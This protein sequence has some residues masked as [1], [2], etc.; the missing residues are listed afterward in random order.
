MELSLHGEQIKQWQ[1]RH[2]GSLLSN[3]QSDGFSRSWSERLP[4]ARLGSDGVLCDTRRAEPLE[5]YSTTHDDEGHWATLYRGENDTLFIDTGTA[6]LRT[7]EDSR[8]KG[9]VVAFVLSMAMTI[10]GA[11][12]SIVPPLS[13]LGAPML[14]GGVLCSFSIIGIGKLVDFE[15]TTV[16]A[17]INDRDVEV[18]PDKSDYGHARLRKLLKC[19]L[20]DRA[21]SLIESS[22]EYELLGR[23][24]EHTY[25]I[26][27]RDR[28]G[29]F[30]YSEPYR[31]MPC[32][33][34]FQGGRDYVVEHIQDEYGPEVYCELFEDELKPA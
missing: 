32:N 6:E 8:L 28:D 23:P 33:Q 16:P 13:S 2:G 14:L 25:Y 3:R 20:Y 19:R 30:L 10:V 15:N 27:L 1:D 31:T 21:E 12:L 5:T 9:V 18:V 11:F 29:S 17:A 7:H 24:E 26:R 22:S 4:N 34:V